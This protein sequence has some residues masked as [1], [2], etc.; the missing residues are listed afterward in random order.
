MI[1]DF[2]DIAEAKEGYLS[3]ERSKLVAKRGIEVGHVF[4]LGTSYTSKMGAKFSDKDGQYKDI[5]MG[6]YGIGVGRLLA[7]CIEANNYENKIKTSCACYTFF[8]C[9]FML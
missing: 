6:C 7:A 1:S 2:V 8:V 9:S 5:L 4:K 3:K